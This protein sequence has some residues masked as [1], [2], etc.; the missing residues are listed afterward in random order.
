MI[1]VKPL[2]KDFAVQIHTDFF[3]NHR[4]H[5]EVA[6]N[7]VLFNNIYNPPI[8]VIDDEQQTGL[9]LIVE[10]M[11]T[12]MQNNNVVLELPTGSRSVSESPDKNDPGKPD[13]I[14]G[15]LMSIASTITQALL[16]P[17]R[18]TGYY[19]VCIKQDPMKGILIKTHSPGRNILKT[20]LRNSIR[21]L[22]ISLSD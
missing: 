22:L 7:G 8:M 15:Q 16:D 1:S 14:A 9:K 2:L 13:E 21:E 17:E 19:F 3:C 18:Y 10:Q 6:C 4:H 20:E 12:E 11:K 5:D